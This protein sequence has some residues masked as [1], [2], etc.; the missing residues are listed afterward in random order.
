MTTVMKNFSHLVNI[1]ENILY[2]L[3]AILFPDAIS[4]TDRKFESCAGSS[5]CWVFGGSCNTV[6]TLLA[7]LCIGMSVHH[8]PAQKVRN[9]PDGS[10]DDSEKFYRPP[11]KYVIMSS[12]SI[13]QWT[14]LVGLELFAG[15]M[16]L[17]RWKAKAEYSHPSKL[18]I[19]IVPS[20]NRR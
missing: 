3:A 2:I 17:Y 15:F 13:A 16:P 5:S 4:P 9:S 19:H 11:G 1:I 18:K 8:P 7:C 20:S 12:L 6:S 10:D 14:G